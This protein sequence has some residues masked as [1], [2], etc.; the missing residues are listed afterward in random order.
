MKEIKAIKALRKSMLLLCSVTVTACGFLFLPFGIQKAQ[1]GEFGFYDYLRGKANKENT[2]DELQLEKLASELPDVQQVHFY[3]KIEAEAAGL[4][5]VCS[6]KRERESFSGQGYVTDFPTQ[7]D[8][9]LVFHV[10]IPA[11]QH[12]RLTIC[13]SSDAPVYNRMQANHVLLEPVYLDSRQWMRITYYGIFLEQGENDFCLNTIDGELNVDYF[14]IENDDSIYDYTLNPEPDLSNEDASEEAQKL[15]QFLCQQQGNKTLTGQYVSDISNQEL[16]L[17]YNIT[18]QL[19]AIRF[20][21]L[22]TENDAEQMEAAIDWS[23]SAQGIVGMMWHW[24]AP[25]F[26]SVFSDQTE[27][28]LYAAFRHKDPKKLA[29]LTQEEAERAFKAGSLSQEAFLLLQDIDHTAAQ[30]EILKNM[31]IPVLW[32]PLY[33]AG[34]GWYW[35]GAYGKDAYN[36]LWSLLYYRLTDYH[37]LNNLIWI[38]NG[39]SAAYLVPNEL[40]DIASVDIYLHP[41][42]EFGSRYEQF[43]TLT[44]ITGG[45]KL[46]GISE[47]GNLPDV[48][49]MK[50]DNAVWSFFGLWCGNYIMNEDGTFSDA[51]YSSQDLFQLYNSDICLSLDDYLAAYQNM[52]S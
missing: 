1:N 5:S 2:A 7:T 33:E 49:M 48:D 15:Y 30:L 38:W 3:R 14:E 22:G 31:K 34:G 23:V 4:S 26:D 28:D 10:Q 45:T 46:L 27:F 43:L 18:G 29:M 52:E 40:F 11:T 21:A 6:V 39:Q 42:V 25:G 12:Y 24:N 9:A 41:E 44:K 37:K 35:W 17:I 36:Q 32:R 51:Y 8:E 50:L 13:A 16:N 20:S 19:P 47:C